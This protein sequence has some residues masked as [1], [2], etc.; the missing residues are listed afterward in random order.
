MT[1]TLPE[2]GGSSL[3]AAGFKV[4]GEV[5]GRSWHTPGS[6]RP[7]VDLHPMQDKLRWEVLA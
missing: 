2:E 7:R 6:G 1:Y 5:N 3:R 4:V